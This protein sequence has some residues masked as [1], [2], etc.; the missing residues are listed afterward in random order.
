MASVAEEVHRSGL[1]LNHEAI[2]A[3]ETLPPS[4]AQEL[5]EATSQKYQNGSL[6]D[7]S[8]YICATINR[9]YVPRSGAQTGILGGKGQ[10]PTGPRGSNYEAAAA[11]LIATKGM[12]KAEEVGLALSDEAVKALLT[13]PASHASEILEAVADK[14]TELRDPSNYVV[15]TIS[16]GYVPRSESNSHGGKG[17]GYGGG[18][19]GSGLYESIYG[20]RGGQPG[21]DNYGQGGK[22][23]G[24]GAPIGGGG[25]FGKSAGYGAQGHSMW[26]GGKDSGKGPRSV[27][28]PEDVTPVESAVLELNEKDLWSGQEISAAT[29]L[30]L[31]CIPQEEALELL[32][33]LQGKGLSK[34]SKG[35]GNLNNYIQAAISKMTREGAAGP[36]AKG[37]G[38]KNRTGNQSRMKAEELGLLLEESTFETLAHMP[39][40]RATSLIEQAAQRQAE[41]EDPNGFIQGEVA[42]D[43]RGDDRALKRARWS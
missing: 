25:N 14:H 4:H 29:M 43:D 39:L 33:N 41:G 24:Y 9:G 30:S 13:I 11:S 5:L 23:P 27:V 10:G 40:R 12:Q 42:G 1:E 3:L 18:K 2:A 22:G 32:Q 21:Y 28:L 15:A 26:G 8:N 34:G 31:R 6:K 36:T 20:G 37:A 17:G 35:I 38:G 19:A 16:R 7:P